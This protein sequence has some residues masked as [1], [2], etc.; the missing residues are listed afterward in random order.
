MYKFQRLT[1][2]I[3]FKLGLLDFLKVTKRF[4]KSL[5]FCHHNGVFFNGKLLIEDCMISIQ[6]K[7][8]LFK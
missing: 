6:V 2:Q 1:R 7:K 8:K 5:L 4:C 3:I